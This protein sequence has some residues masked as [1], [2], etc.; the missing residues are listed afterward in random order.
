MM[1]Q[2]AQKSLKD[3]QQQVDESPKRRTQEIGRFKHRKLQ[4]DTRLNSIQKP[5]G[6]KEG[7]A[8]FPNQSPYKSLKNPWL[9]SQSLERRR[10]EE[11]RERR[12][13]RQERRVGARE[14]EKLTEPRGV[15]G[16]MKP[17]NSRLENLNYP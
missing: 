15:R 4:I 13:G 12:R 1:I 2:V 10:E 3:P 6:H 9:N 14:K 11:G 7:R 16:F 8:S 17:T 5:R